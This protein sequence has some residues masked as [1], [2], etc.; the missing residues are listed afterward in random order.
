MYPVK[1]LGV[2][3]IVDA[4]I[5]YFTIN[6]IANTVL[7]Q[8]AHIGDTILHVDNSVRF[9][10]NDFI[11]LMDNNSSQQA[12]TGQLAGAEFHGVAKNFQGTGLLYLTE[13]LQ[14]DFL[15][16]NNARL[17][18][19]IKKAIL[20]EKDILYGD[21]AVINAD[22]VAICVEP[23]SKSQEWLATR[24]L[25]T[26]IQLSIMVY[27]KSGGQDQKVE[28]Q[29]IRICNAYADAVNNLLMS[30]LHFDVVVDSVP[31]ARDAH[32]GDEGVWIYC[33]QVANWTPRHCMDYEVQD[34][35]GAQ[36]L[37]KI[38]YPDSSSE[39]SSSE[40]MTSSS[41]ISHPSS[42]SSISSDSSSSQ[43]SQS[44]SSSSSSYSSASSEFMT[45]SSSSPSSWSSQSV[46]SKETPT[47][48]TSSS[49]SISSQS[50]PET[51]CWVQ[52]NRPLTR[53]FLVNDK[54][55]LRRIDRYAYDSRVDNIEYGMVQKGSVLL[56]VAKLSWFGKET[57]YMA[58]PQVSLEDQSQ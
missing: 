31:L 38:V 6:L 34:N 3:E 45:S 48:N 51:V 36:Q 40:K 54:A 22:Y 5:N 12:I 46:T 13:P 27:V 33:S 44:T 26:N 43:S 57:E 42:S 23:S 16:S 8:D 18:K 52:L 17:Q 37:L 4:M 15:V 32:I 47:S 35:N 56:K 14:Q 10:K 29:A 30:N 21:R 2:E 41:S 49:S 19:T 39:S 50:S 58:F 24:L 11:L 53:N 28:E 7:T 1:T 20:Y 25:G 55:F 9:R